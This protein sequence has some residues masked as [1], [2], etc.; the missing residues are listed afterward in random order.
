[1]IAANFT[2]AEENYEEALAL[3]NEIGEAQTI[4]TTQLALARLRLEQGKTDL[5]VRAAREVRDSLREAKMTEDQI[6]ATCLLARALLAQGKYAEAQSELGTVS[7]L[8]R[9]EQSLGPRLEFAIVSAMAQDAAGKP[10][11]ARESLRRTIVEATKAGFIVYELEAQFALAN[12]GI[13]SGKDVAVR[14]DLEKLERDAKAR[15]FDL[16]ARKAA[17]ARGV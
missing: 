4:R 16:I 17:A 8:A 11:L 13:K 5:A 6:L 2:G 9:K 15:G 7:A 12:V 10:L 14:A 1:L 3:S